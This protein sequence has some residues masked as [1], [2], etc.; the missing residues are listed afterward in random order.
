MEWWKKLPYLEKMCQTPQ[1]YSK[2][3]WQHF[4]SF[5]AKM[6]QMEWWKKF[7][8]NVDHIS[9]LFW[10]KPQEKLKNLGCLSKADNY[11]RFSLY[12]P[13]SCPA[14]IEATDLLASGRCQDWERVGGEGNRELIA[15]PSNPLFQHFCFGGVPREWGLRSVLGCLDPSPTPPPRCHA[16]SWSGVEAN[17]LALATPVAH[18][19]RPRTT[20]V[21]FTEV[22]EGWSGCVIR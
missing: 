7:T 2:E 21:L 8:E 3:N 11:G 13:Y 12:P 10:Y 18:P 17:T 22:D 16:R 9:P 15:F 6:Y 20:S 1:K 5:H 4:L 19:T 14:P